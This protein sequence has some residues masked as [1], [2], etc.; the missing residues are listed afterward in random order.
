MIKGSLVEL[1]ALGAFELTEISPIAALGIPCVGNLKS[2]A[3]WKVI[4]MSRFC[5][6]IGQADQQVDN[7]W[8]E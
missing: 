4:E 8:L 2:E 5:P 7:I 6:R 3:L 1:A